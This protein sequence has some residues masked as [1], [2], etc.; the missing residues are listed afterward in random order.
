VLGG[1]EYCTRILTGAQLASRGLAPIVLVS[2]P[3]IFAAHESDFTIGCATRQGYP[4]ALFRALLSGSD[5][6]RTE[7]KLLGDYLRAHHIR[8]ILL[9]TSN[10]H[11]HR[12]ARLFRHSNPDL[13]VY[14]EPAPDPFF[15]PATWWRTRTGQRIF[16]LEW[17]KTLASLVGY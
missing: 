10:Y 11:T 7:S 9:V 3:E 12:A 6:T 16:L 1:D 13:T 2:G 17:T 15:T 4:A 14:A 5:S 8:S